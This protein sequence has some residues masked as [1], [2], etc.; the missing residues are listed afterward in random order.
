MAWLCGLVIWS[1]LA[2]I[3]PDSY[4][5]WSD[6]V[7]LAIYLSGLARYGQA[8]PKNYLAWSDV[9]SACSLWHWCTR[10][11]LMEVDRT[12]SVLRLGHLVTF[13]L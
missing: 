4:L 6:M 9:I 8:R 13:S 5:V 11:R 10:G 3:W 7:W 1:D 2:K 12:L